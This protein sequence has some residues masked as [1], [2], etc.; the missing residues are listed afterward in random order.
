[1]TNWKFSQPNFEYQ[2]VL[3]EQI[4]TFGWLGHTHFAYDLVSQFQP[5]KVVELGTHWGVSF[6]AFCQA[7]KDHSAATK[8][9]AVDTW[10]GEK[11]AGQ[12]DERVIKL[13]KKI[14]AKFFSELSIHFLRQ[15]FDQAVA[16]FADESIDILH[17]DGLHTYEAVKHDFQTWLPKV[18]ADGLILFH[19]TTEKS[20]GFGVYR[21]WRELT[22]K[23]P[24]HFEFT[25]SHGLGVIC[26]NEKFW[27]QT[28]AKRELWAAHYATAGAKELATIELFKTRQELK[29]TQDLL[30]QT[31]EA[32][33]GVVAHNKQLTKTLEETVTHAQNLEAMVANIQSS[34]AYKL[35][36]GLG[37]LKRLIK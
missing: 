6:F 19:D 37:S 16:D 23:Y 32:L 15:T 8:L 7:A 10:Q 12:Y 21:L 35:A 30:T 31:R 33:D 4:D 3:N 1:M 36:H 24:M 25:H 22:K 5:D 20:R 14:K 28:K 18:K 26:L 29:N 27:R 9:Y 11:H 34:K 13:V 17:I 2:A